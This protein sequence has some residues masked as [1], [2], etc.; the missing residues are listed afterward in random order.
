MQGRNL[1]KRLKQTSKTNVVVETTAWTPR[2]PKTELAWK[3][4]GLDKI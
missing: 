3:S 2:T 1:A 4:Y